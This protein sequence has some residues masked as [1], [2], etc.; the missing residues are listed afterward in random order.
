MT[1]PDRDV[2]YGVALAIRY[3]AIRDKIQSRDAQVLI[4][5]IQSEVVATEK[6]SPIIERSPLDEELRR[7]ILARRLTTAALAAEAFG[8]REDA[9]RASI[10]RNPTPQRY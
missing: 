3:P 4:D 6:P 5:Y 8:A 9:K 7:Q 10:P 1:I 2:A